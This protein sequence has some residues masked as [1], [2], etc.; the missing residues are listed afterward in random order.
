MNATQLFPNATS[1]PATGV[2]IVSFP[3]IDIE[4]FYA[5]T[6]INIVVVWIFLSHRCIRTFISE[7]IVRES[8]FWQCDRQRLAHPRCWKVSY[9]LDILHRESQKL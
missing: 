9:F 4:N 5:I 6:C 2:F 3:S 8:R 7:W 1:D